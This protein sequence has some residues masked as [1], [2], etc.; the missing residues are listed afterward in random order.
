MP[1]G[2]IVRYVEQ[3]LNLNELV[4]RQ[5]ATRLHLCDLQG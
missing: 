1:F 3:P 2:R 5:M 4:G